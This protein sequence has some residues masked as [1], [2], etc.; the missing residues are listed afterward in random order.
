MLIIIAGLFITL[1]LLWGARKI[2]NREM[3]SRLVRVTLYCI[4]WII[5]AGIVVTVVALAV[6]YELMPGAILVIFAILYFVSKKKKI[7]GGQP[8]IL[9]EYNPIEEFK[10][11]INIVSLIGLSISA[12]L[13]LLMRVLI[14]MD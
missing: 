7:K 1:I 9:T 12:G 11:P 14:A 6:R 3:V 2:L 5:A 4:S 8:P 13:L 10:R